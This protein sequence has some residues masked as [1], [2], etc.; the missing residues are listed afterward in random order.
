MLSKLGQTGVNVQGTMTLS[1]SYLTGELPSETLQ[2]SGDRG[3][4]SGAACTME[5][6]PYSS[7]G[8]WLYTCWPKSP[9]KELSHYTVDRGPGIADSRLCHSCQAHRC[10]LLCRQSTGPS[11]DSGFI[12]IY[13][14]DQISQVRCSQLPANV[15]G[16]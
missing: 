7:P 9:L 11:R 12:Q 13:L 16:Y 10:Q 3:V 15:F 2:C 14:Y 8:S 5:S 1:T 6:P 4:R